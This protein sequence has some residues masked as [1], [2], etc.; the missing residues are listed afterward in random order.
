M[1][2]PRSKYAVSSLHGVAMSPRAWHAGDARAA[3]LNMSPRL[4]PVASPRHIPKEHADFLAARAAQ[5]QAAEAARAAHAANALSMAKLRDAGKAPRLTDAVRVAATAERTRDEVALRA[6]LLSGAGACMSL[7]QGSLPPK[8]FA[9]AVGQMPDASASLWLESF[10]HCVFRLGAAFT[11]M[12]EEV[13]RLLGSA[14]RARYEQLARELSAASGRARAELDSLRA[15]AERATTDGERECADL[16]RS[17]ADE[18]GRRQRVRRRWARATAAA[19]AYSR[20]QLARRD[21]A[22]RE[23]EA[24][25]NGPLADAADLVCFHAQR[26]L[27]CAEACLYVQGEADE[28]SRGPPPLYRLRGRHAGVAESEAATALCCGGDAALVPAKSLA[29]LAIKAN[30]FEWLTEARADK[31]YSDDADRLPGHPRPA[32]TL[33]IPLS[34]GAGTLRAL[35]RCARPRGGPFGALEVAEMRGAAPLFSLALRQS[36]A[37]RDVKLAKAMRSVAALLTP[38]RLELAKVCEAWCREV[39]AVLGADRCTL[40]LYD[41]PRNQLVSYVAE[42]VEKQLTLPLDA[43]VGIAAT[44]AKSR[45]AINIESAYDDPRFNRAVDDV[46]G[47]T[48]RSILA[49]PFESCSSGEL[50]GVCQLLNKVGTDGAHFDGD[51]EEIL[52]SVLKLAALAIEN[53]QLCRDY[54]LLVKQMEGS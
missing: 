37:S 4:P 36:A 42:G 54:L 24:A 8:V 51:D 44:C 34:D 17:A 6:G 53:N 13:S 33:L 20:K 46:S 9:A 25:A 16:L 52:G 3:H 14:N 31:R 7:L 48:T 39:Q 49:M 50:M 22:V 10:G 47:Y 12:R 27:G 30:A 15:D 5:Q 23:L 40:F 45:Q 11:E 43:G 28:G 21:A 1:D 19:L 18:F 29:G 2:S 41:E 26:M 35:L 38:G 32:E